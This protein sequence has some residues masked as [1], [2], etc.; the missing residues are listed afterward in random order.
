MQAIG[1]AYVHVIEGETGGD[2]N[3]PFDY[4]ALRSH[5][6]GVWMVNNG[7]DAA[8]AEAAIA[9]GHANMVAIG[10][11]MIA[12]TDYP[13]HIANGAPLNQLEQATLSD[14]NAHGYTYYPE[15]GRT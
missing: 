4:K 14:G 11:Q 1:I 7:Y 13:A 15:N 9:S 8:M 12:N 6:Q 5:F 3:V 10:R 2:R